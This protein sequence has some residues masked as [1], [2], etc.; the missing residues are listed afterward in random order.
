MTQAPPQLCARCMVRPATRPKVYCFLCRDA[1]NA[2]MAK[3]YAV[4]KSCAGQE[5]LRQTIVEERM[6]AFAVYGWSV[7]N[8]IHSTARAYPQFEQPGDVLNYLARPK[9]HEYRTAETL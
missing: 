4:R 9:R 8:L 2:C 3:I 7:A 1:H 6:K 5:T